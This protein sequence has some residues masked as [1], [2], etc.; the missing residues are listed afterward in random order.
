MTPS[1]LEESIEGLILALEGFDRES[2]QKTLR[3]FAEAIREEDP[4]CPG[5]DKCKAPAQGCQ[6]NECVI[7]RHKSDCAV[8]N[9]PARRNGPCDCGA[10]PPEPASCNRCGFAGYSREA[11]MK[12]AIECA[13]K[14][15]PTP[16]CEL[17]RCNGSCMEQSECTVCHKRAAHCSC[18]VCKPPPREEKKECCCDSYGKGCCPCNPQ[19]AKSPSPLPAEVQKA[20]DY[21]CWNHAGVVKETA[22]LSQRL[23]ELARLCLSL[24]RKE[25][26]R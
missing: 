18:Y 10:K 7:F 19:P 2:L 16:E 15:P 4:D 17:G 3:A 14:K 26:A 13:G 23:E 24:A 25:G 1:K 20:V 5:C 9:E 8:H 21:I 12:H 11:Y 22:S 6:C